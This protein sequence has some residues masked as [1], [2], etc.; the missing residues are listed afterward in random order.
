MLH[1]H[2]NTHMCT[3]KQKESKGARKEE[4]KITSVSQHSALGKQDRRIRSLRLALVSRS[5]RPV[6]VTERWKWGWGGVF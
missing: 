1:T 4:K 5:A 6:C 2:E 3:H